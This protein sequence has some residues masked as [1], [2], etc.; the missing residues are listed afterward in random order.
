MTTKTCHLRFD[1]S[2][3]LWEK[4]LFDPIFDIAQLV[5]IIAASAILAAPA[6]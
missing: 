2:F 3:F 6:V 5:D 4:M 1:A